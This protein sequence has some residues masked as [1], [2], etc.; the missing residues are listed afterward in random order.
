MERL[1]YLLTKHVAD[2]EHGFTISTG[3]GSLR[4]DKKDAV[5]IARIVRSI[6]LEQIERARKGRAGL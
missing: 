1:S 5:P 2:M 4:I 3:Y 6:L